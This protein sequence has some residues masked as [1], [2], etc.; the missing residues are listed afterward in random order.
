MS[1]S[2]LHT[3]K[4]CNKES[5]FRADQNFC[6]TECVSTY[7]AAHRKGRSLNEQT[8]L[9]PQQIQEIELQKLRDKREGKDARIAFLEGEVLR[10]EKE[11]E[12][13]SHI[14]E[15]TP[16]IL[17]VE[18]RAPVGQSESAAVVVWSDWHSE[19]EVKPGQV[20]G[21][22]EHNIEI[23]DRRVAQLLQGTV[24]WFK[25]E[26]AQT[27]ISK[28]VL[29]LLGDFF[30]GSIHED[31]AESNLLP[32]T[33]AAYRAGGLLITGIEYLL[34]ELPPDVSIDVVC[35][36]GN[37]GRMTK[38]QRISTEIGNSLEQFVYYTIRD[39]FAAKKETRVRFLIATGYHSF[40]R[41]FDGRYEIRW[42]HGHQ[43][44]YWGGIGGI[45]IPVNK[46]IA[47]WNRA[48]TV[49][50]DV[51][52]HFHQRFDGGNFICN[53]SLIGYNPFAVSIKAGYERPSQVFFLVNK[54]YAEKT[55]VCPIF[56]E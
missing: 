3:C 30:S 56:V 10:L 19:E 52:G 47:Q 13:I 40:T 21:K 33:E 1:K 16:Q 48:H 43:M 42:H 23:S 26:A 14:S 54:E 53:G 22:N 50:L 36:G 46:A 11:V 38:K 28:L 37:H 17:D 41:F 9:T 5:V 44:S 25:I 35:H 32:P 15:V 34:K 29:A 2:I 31:L 51:F 45:T 12:A 39:Y 18:P 7:R 24:C 4:G 20:G 6:S 55:A 49:N 27:K 8:G